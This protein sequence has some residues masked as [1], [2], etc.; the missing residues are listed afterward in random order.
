MSLANS[1]ADLASAP[2]PAYLLVMDSDSIK[3]DV[4]ANEQI[5]RPSQLFARMRAKG[6]GVEHVTI[7]RTT[8]RSNFCITASRKALLQQAQRLQWE[9]E[10]KYNGIVAPMTRHNVSHFAHD[11]ADFFSHAESLMLLASLLDSIQLTSGDHRIS[12][13]QGSFF[14][15]SLLRS[16]SSFHSAA[17]ANRLLSEGIE[18]GALLDA[19]P[20]HDL[21]ARRHASK[22]WW[23][24]K[25]KGFVQELSE[26]FGSNV[27]T[28]FAFLSHLRLQL[29]LPALLG[30]VVYM[31]QSGRQQ[32]MQAAVQRAQHV[33]DAAARFENGTCVQLAPSACGGDPAPPGQHG[34]GNFSSPAG[35]ACGASLCFAASA[36]GQPSQPHIIAAGAANG[37]SLGFG[38]LVVLW[39]G[40]MLKLWQRK[41]AQLKFAWGSAAAEDDGS[42]LRVQYE[43]ASLPLAPVSL[44]QDAF[45]HVT[46]TEHV[47]VWVLRRL[48]V[49]LPIMLT[50]LLLYTSIMMTAEWLTAY[51]ED[52]ITHFWHLDVGE[53]VYRR[54]ESDAAAHDSDLVKEL[55]PWMVQALTL[56][57]TVAYVGLLPALQGVATWV[58]LALTRFENHRTQSAFDNALLLKKVILT[59]FTY[60]VGLFYAAFVRRNLQV[61]Q[62]R[63]FVALVL[64]QVGMAAVELVVQIRPYVTAMAFAKMDG[65]SFHGA[66][67]AVG[68]SEKR[69]GGGADGAKGGAAAKVKALRGSDCAS[70]AAALAQRELLPYDVYDDMLELFVLFSH[71]V[72]FAGVYPLGA[73]F[74]AGTSLLEMPLDASKLLLSRRPRPS[75]AN[76]QSAWMVAFAAVTALALLSNLMLAAV[77]FEQ[78]GGLV[79]Y[80]GELLGSSVMDSDG[81]QPWNDASALLAANSGSSAASYGSPEYPAEVAPSVSFLVAPDLLGV[82]GTALQ[83]VL[84]W[85]LTPITPM[86]VVTAQYLLHVA[87]WTIA[88]LFGRCHALQLV[89]ML[90]ERNTVSGMA[91][92]TAQWA[93]L[94]TRPAAAGNAAFGGSGVFVSGMQAPRWAWYLGIAVLEHA[95]LSL[96]V[97]GATGVSSEPA[98]VSDAKH[99][100]RAYLENLRFQGAK[101]RGRGGSSDADG[102]RSAEEQPSMLASPGSG[103]SRSVQRTE[104]GGF[105]G[106]PD[107]PASPAMQ[108][109]LGEFVHHVRSMSHAEAQAFVETLVQK[110]GDSGVVLK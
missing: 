96:L 87:K 107:L 79:H 7:G 103:I 33:L 84:Q 88:L 4:F 44:S 92:A 59:F 104:D 76:A 39:A 86:V 30:L 60:F 105:G 83:W 27:A 100:R 93:L 65:A 99:A 77:A 57:P 58:A 43:P 97:L 110:Y 49:T 26:Y 17:S 81:V 109:P 106:V 16:Q 10:T 2:Q 78:G 54:R 61:L 22:G 56:L 48:C 31:L 47:F 24:V 68:L 11:Q 25:D 18:R 40:T 41:Q 23:R 50:L 52:E 101:Q 108:T 85:I 62:S 53:G 91:S 46:A 73:A 28:Y 45:G 35:P 67:V 95:V 75:A 42:R 82:L 89:H 51:T 72:M 55:S 20:V 102:T 9:K 70:A 1:M 64:K 71:V 12:T 15:Q 29:V 3:L 14:A 94:G 8:N 13:Q 98:S 66:G 5:V 63:L 90:L 69:E 6:L 38:I 32:Y 80:A 74:V 19:Y 37:I 21:K 34:G 36:I